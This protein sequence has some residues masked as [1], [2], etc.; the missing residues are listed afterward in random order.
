MIY[1]LASMGHGDSV[2][3]VDTNFP[4]ASVARTTSH[5]RAIYL[6]GVDIPHALEAILALLPLD[7]F[8]AEPIKRMLVVDNPEVVPQVQHKVAEVLAR[9]GVETSVGGLDRFEFYESARAC[10]AIFAT[11]ERRFYGNYLIA[12]GIIGPDEQ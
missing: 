2:A 7:T 12:K 5:G 10:Y 9:A 6:P 11:G 8:V 1:V 3:L 4:A